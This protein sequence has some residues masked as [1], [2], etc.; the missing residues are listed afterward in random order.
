M[1]AAVGAR[2]K[3]IKEKQF[4]AHH[5]QSKEYQTSGKQAHSK[6]KVLRRRY[7]W[8]IRRSIRSSWMESEKGIGVSNRLFEGFFAIT[9]ATHLTL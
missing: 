4:D 6:V 3:E 5:K 7:Q 8:E 2:I 9:I 1:K